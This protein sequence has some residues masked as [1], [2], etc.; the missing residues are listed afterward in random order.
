MSNTFVITS[1]PSSQAYG[2]L[3]RAVLGYNNIL[4]NSSVTPNST[5]DPK[6]PMALAYDFKTNTEYSPI[7]TSG[8][9]VI[10]IVQ[11]APSLISYFG[12]FSKNA[13][14]CNLSFMVEVQDYSTGLYTNVGWRGG[15]ENGSPQMLSFTPINSIQQKVTIYFTSKCYIA[16]LAM[17]EAVVFSRTVSAGYQPARNASIDEVSNFTT[18]GNNFVQGRRLVNGFQEKAPV[19]YQEYSFIDEWWRD[20]MNHALDAKP[21]FFMANNQTPEYCVYGLQNPKTLTKPS[22]K[23]SHQTDIEFDI[24]G[25]A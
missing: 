12:L 9:V 5:S 19:N 4:V 3:C 10:T 6:Y 25:W 18:D 2:N 8:S 20:F 7:I 22:Y 17:G 21:I 24:N 15:F 13:K 23:N 11:S 1:S 16:S 14:T